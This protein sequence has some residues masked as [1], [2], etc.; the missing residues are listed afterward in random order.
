MEKLINY[1]KFDERFADLFLK[2]C[3]KNQ[4]KI[5]DKLLIV[6]DLFEVMDFANI[7]KNKALELGY[8]DVQILIEDQDQIHDFLF[9]NDLDAIKTSK[10]FDRSMWDEF[11]K[12]NNPILFIDSRVPNL[13]SDIDTSKLDLMARVRNSSSS[14]YRANVG[15]RIFPWSLT[16]YP[17]ERWAKSVFGDID[18]AYIKLYNAMAKACMLDKDDYILEWDKFME[19][20][21]IVKNNLNNLDIDSLHFKNELGTDLV[22]G[23][24]KGYCFLNLDKGTGVINNMPSYEIFASPD[25]RKT[26]GIV[27]SSK[28]LFYLGSVIK[29]FWIEFKDGAIVNYDAKMGKDLLETLLSNQSSSLLGEVALVDKNSPLAKMNINFNDILYDENCSSHLAL[30]GGSPKSVIGGETMSKEELVKLGINFSDIHVDFM[31]GT[32]D[33]DVWA[34]TKKGKKLVLRKGSFTDEMLK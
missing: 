30:G 19:Y 25:C 28:P 17:N 26:N 14:Y 22:V 32:D 18:D 3:L 6:I 8:K 13:M 9:N 16:G 33:T 5:H 34:N 2:K 10:L 11:A 23:L 29:D 12:N 15:K 1:N 24:P 31:I 27:Y 20:S 7:L 21:N 4:E